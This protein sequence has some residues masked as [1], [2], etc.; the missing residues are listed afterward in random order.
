MAQNPLA[1]EWSWFHK[2]WK[3]RAPRA[4]VEKGKGVTGEFLGF[5]LLSGR[6]NSRK[7]LIPKASSKPRA[8]PTQPG[9]GTLTLTSGPN[10]GSQSPLR[11]YAATHSPFHQS[12]LAVW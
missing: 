2:S 3:R 5:L 9:S 10:S 8:W 6:F 7:H 1:R 4:M 12:L 11:M